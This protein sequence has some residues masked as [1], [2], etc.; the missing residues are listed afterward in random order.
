[1]S[2]APLPPNARKTLVSMKAMSGGG[3]PLFHG[4]GGVGR[5]WMGGRARRRRDGYYCMSVLQLKR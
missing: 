4:G 5:F 3:L 2:R 1:M